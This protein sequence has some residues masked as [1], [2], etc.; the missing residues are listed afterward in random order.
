MSYYTVFD[1]ESP[2]ESLPELPELSLFDTPSPWR[3]IFPVQRPQKRVRLS[4]PEPPGRCKEITCSSWQFTSLEG[5]RVLAGE[6]THPPLQR[7]QTIFN[8]R[9]MEVSKLLQLGPVFTSKHEH[10]EPDLLEL[11]PLC[12]VP[13][14]LSEA[15]SPQPP[16][17]LCQDSRAGWLS[18][19]QDSHSF[20]CSDV[21]AWGQKLDYCSRHMSCVIQHLMKRDQR[22]EQTFCSGSVMRF[23][24][25]SSTQ[26]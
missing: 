9:S 12:S 23:V 14:C 21:T 4:A 17:S 13:S 10:A 22:R 6:E 16:L 1:V 7:P 26:C 19:G 5:D 15:R 11:R 2:L 24:D 18:C 25:T 8:E 20:P 3:S